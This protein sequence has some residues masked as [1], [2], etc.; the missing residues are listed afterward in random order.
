MLLYTI[1]ITKWTNPSCS[2]NQSQEHHYPSNSFTRWIHPRG[3]SSLP[4]WIMYW[5]HRPSRVRWNM[6]KR[7][8]VDTGVLRVW[9]L[10][11]RMYW[12]TCMY[13]VRIL[14]LEL[15]GLSNEDVFDMHWYDIG[16]R[17]YQ[18]ATRRLDVLRIHRD[19]IQAVLNTWEKH[20]SGCGCS[21]CGTMFNVTSITTVEINHD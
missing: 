10:T 2:K 5:L 15:E 8:V 4:P 17:D 14:L 16:T 19:T 3:F 6:W 1:L 20:R 18:W 7:S 21:G 13:Y 12:R 9:Y 11:Y